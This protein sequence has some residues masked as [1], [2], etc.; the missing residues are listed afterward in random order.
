MISIANIFQNIYENKSIKNTIVFLGILVSI[1]I[2]KPPP[3]IP[4]DEITDKDYFDFLVSPD[5]IRKQLPELS[6]ESE[7]WLDKT[8]ETWIA[9]PMH[10]QLAEDEEKVLMGMG[11]CFVPYMSEP[12]LEPN[13]EVL[14]AIGKVISSGK[15][16]KKYSLMPG[17]YHLLMGSGAYKH[18]IVRKLKIK[19][20][21][22][23]QIIPDWCGLSIEV[24]DEN[25]QPFHGEYELARMDKF[26]PF[27][28]GFGSDPDLGEKAKTWILKPG[29]YKIFGVGESYNTLNNFVTVRLLPGEFVKFMLIQSNN[30]AENNEKLKIIGGGVLDI[31][32]ESNISSNWQ[33]GIN[34][35]GGLSF[36]AVQDLND[37]TKKGNNDESINLSL[38]SK[39]T[40]K[41]DRIEWITRPQINERIELKNW[42]MATLN[43]PLDEIRIPSILTFKVFSRFGPYGRVELRTELFPEYIRI[44]YDTLLIKFDEDC[45]CI[46]IDSVSTDFKIQPSFTPFILETGLGANINALDYRYIKARILAGLG[47][48]YTKI[49]NTFKK[50]DFNIDNLTL[51]DSLKFALITNSTENYIIYHKTHDVSTVEAGPEIVMYLT[52][53][54]GNFATLETEFKVLFPFDR[55]KEPNVDLRSTLSLRLFKMVSLDYDFKYML[56][57]VEKKNEINHGINL[58]FSYISR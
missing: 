25:N 55:L 19:E 56:D 11:A 47:L 24:V 43:N 37:S 50:D 44:P 38:R 1:I 3:E 49:R 26:I 10:E 48:K 40:F 53:L 30:D 45:N 12:E 36:D 21:D 9:P 23:T 46:E 52:I 14:N 42:N 33:Y 32:A 29:T 13:I 17:L 54:M 41:K 18:R 15:S 7:T 8:S 22:I 27:G 5:S 4:G 6:P 31:N 58:R 51:S 35:G 28:R 39:F 2:A 16:G 20:G 34:F 57:K